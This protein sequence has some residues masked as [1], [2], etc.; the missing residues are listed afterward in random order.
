MHTRHSR[1]TLRFAIGALLLAPVLSSCGFN[2]ATDRVNDHTAGKTSQEATV[3]AANVLIVAGQP[4]S[5][6]LVGLLANNDI[7]KDIVLT[8]VT[9]GTDETEADLE[10]VTVPAGGSAQLHDAG[11]RIEGT[12][13]AG[14]V[15]DVTLTFANGEVVELATVPGR[16]PVRTSTTGLSRRRRPR[17]SR[18]A[19]TRQPT[20]CLLP[21]S[22]RRRS[23]GTRSN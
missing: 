13:E 16:H 3:D 20:G 14:E 4:D 5:G 23:H 7:D 2:Y 1:R 22:T 10:P 19:A 21:A 9:S 11:I 8:G 12:F 6:T 17:A 15:Y 18:R